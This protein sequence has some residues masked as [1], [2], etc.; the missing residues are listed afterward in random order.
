MYVVD[1]KYKLLNM[2]VQVVQFCNTWLT[3]GDNIDHQ[4][5]CLDIFIE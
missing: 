2:T 3:I 5:I 4:R 1:H